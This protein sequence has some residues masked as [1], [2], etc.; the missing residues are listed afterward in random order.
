MLPFLVST[1]II[2][3]AVTI[4]FEVWIRYL[5]FEF[6]ADTLCRFS[7]FYSTWTIA[8]SL[9]QSVLYSLNDVLVVV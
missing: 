3:Q 2:K 9:F 6:F 8:A 7:S 4:S 5:L 1:F